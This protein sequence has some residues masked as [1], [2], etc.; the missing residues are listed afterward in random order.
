MT[1]LSRQGQSLGRSQQA[2]ALPDPRAI[3]DESKFSLT[4]EA[5]YTAA[6]VRMPLWT[7]RNSRNDRALLTKALVGRLPSG[8]RFRVECLLTP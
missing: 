8:D 4:V 2:R 6:S 5:G 7:P 3:T 1:C